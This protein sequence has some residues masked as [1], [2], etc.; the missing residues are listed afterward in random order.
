[1]APPFNV[2]PLGASDRREGLLTSRTRVAGPGLFSWEVLI[3]GHC[4]HPTRKKRLEV[5]EGFSKHTWIFQTFHAE[6]RAVAHTRMHESLLSG[7]MSACC[8]KIWVD[9]C[10]TFGPGVGRPPLPAAEGRAAAWQK[11]TPSEK[12][13]LS[14]TSTRLQCPVKIYARGTYYIIEL[15]QVLGMV[16]FIAWAGDLPI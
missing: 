11:G 16:W 4:L 8:W 1:M 2:A 3:N 10:K 5:Q 6:V 13:A 14:P 15:A 7:R 12:K 9:P